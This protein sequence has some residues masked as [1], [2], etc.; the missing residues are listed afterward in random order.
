MRY[1]LWG[2]PNSGSFMVEAALAEAKQPV[3]LVDL[4]LTKDEHRAADYLEVSPLGK[5]PA[6]RF[7]DGSVMTE[8]AAILLAL[9]EA[10]P[11][12]G[13]MPPRESPERRA[14]LRWLLF[15]ATEIYPL[16]EMSDYPH[17][18]A[19]PETSDVGLR[20]VVRT[21]LR[22]RWRAVHQAA[23]GDGTFLPS[24]FSAVDLSVAVISRWEV[25]DEWRAKEG[26]KLDAITRAVAERPSISRVWQRHFGPEA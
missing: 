20:S 13:L 1:T 7:P 11:D 12:A 14:A 24:G 15:I 19:P 2:E 18:F 9:D 10:H 4:D 21:R 16:I 22:E 5:V 26:R 6:L 23:S 25:G 3:E 8:S 17:R